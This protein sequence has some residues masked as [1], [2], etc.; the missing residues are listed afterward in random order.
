MDCILSYTT[1]G[2]NPITSIQSYTEGSIPGSGS[3][4]YECC[5]SCVSE[6][7]CAYSV[8]DNNGNC[9]LNLIGG[10]CADNTVAGIFYTSTVG[11]NVGTINNGPCGYLKFAGNYDN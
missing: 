9:N 5:Q 11:T 10:S 1:D 7:G 4:A 8:F 3:N 2:G 6:A